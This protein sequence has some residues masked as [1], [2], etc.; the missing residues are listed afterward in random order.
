MYV[1]TNQVP[2][3]V[4]DQEKPDDKVSEEL[5]EADAVDASRI[6]NNA[7]VNGCYCQVN[8]AKNINFNVSVVD[9]DRG[10]QILANDEV[11]D[12]VNC[13]E[14]ADDEV[15][16]ESTEEDDVKVY[17]IE[18]DASVDDGHYQVNLAKN[19]H[20]NVSVDKDK[21]HQ[22]TTNEVPDYADYQEKPDDEVSE[23]LKDEDDV[24]FSGIKG[25]TSLNDGHCQV[26]LDKATLMFQL[27]ERGATRHQPIRTLIITSKTVMFQLRRRCQMILLISVKLVKKTAVYLAR[28]KN[29][30]VSYACWSS[31]IMQ[32]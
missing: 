31:L 7:S 28:T 3:C 26:D 10:H 15:S 29:T 11:S 21:G 24:K 1:P 17:R 12:Y 14:E 32:A 25:N 4:N 23:E 18:E 16:E 5:N 20:S 30:S 27:I 19:I 9:K 6:K 8:L 2:D 22:I 13:Q